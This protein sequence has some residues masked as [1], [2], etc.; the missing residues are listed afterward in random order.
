MIKLLAEILF[1][2]LMLLL[3]VYSAVMIYVL[4]RFGESKIFGFV[5]SAFYFLLMVSFYAAASVQ[6]ENLPFPEI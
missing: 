3:A 5:L 1:Y 4:L 2:A 6:F